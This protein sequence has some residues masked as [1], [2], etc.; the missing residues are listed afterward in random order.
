MKL[1]QTAYRRLH[2]RYM[3]VWLRAIYG[4]AMYLPCMG[5]CDPAVAKV[6]GGGSRGCREEAARF[7]AG[8]LS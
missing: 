7:V 5:R 8:C 2:W 6:S 1:L 3:Q 4:A